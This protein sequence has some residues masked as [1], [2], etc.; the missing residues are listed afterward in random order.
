MPGFSPSAV[1]RGRDRPLQGRVARL[2]IDDAVACGGRRVLFDDEVAVMERGG[3]REPE[4]LLNLDE[5][6]LFV[7]APAGRGSDG[8][9]GTF[10]LVRLADGASLA[11]MGEL[12][13]DGERRWVAAYEFHVGDP[14]VY[15]YDGSCG[16]LPA[17]VVARK[18]QHPLAAVGELLTEPE[19]LTAAAGVGVGIVVSVWIAPAV[20]TAMGIEGT[21]AVLATEVALDVLIAGGTEAAIVYGMTGDRDRAIRGLAYAGVGAAGGAVI[22]RALMRLAQCR[23]LLATAGHGGVDAGD[24]RAGEE[25]LRGAAVAVRR[26]G[27]DEIVEVGKRYDKVVAALNGDEVLAETLMRD[28]IT[29]E[30]TDLLGIVLRGGDEELAGVV[31]AWKILIGNSTIRRQVASLESI[32]NYLNRYPDRGPLLKSL[33]EDAVENEDKFIS[34][35][36][37]LD[38]DLE[39]VLLSSNSL[40]LDLATVNARNWLSSKPGWHDVIIHGTP[41]EFKVLTGA[42][43]WV[44][45]NHRILV[46]YMSSKGYTGGKVRLVSC[47]TGV[48][49]DAVGQHLSNKLGVEVIAPKGYISVLPDGTHIVHSDPNDIFGT[50]ITDGWRSFIP[51]TIP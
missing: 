25:L 16:W 7:D 18:Y 8:S 41:D 39:S 1:R 24:L 5:G 22:G 14:A 38:D 12:V 2:R 49:H 27:G 6:D 37:R 17:E 36:N 15:M 32:S 29:E 3:P 31:R 46:N 40:G 11:L 51:G 35:V 44:S 13:I 42:D 9:S 47:Q 43:E 34:T 10:E 48:F 20:V 26:S 30:G 28:A 45:L 50:Q 21:A 33:F 19:V 23:R 4:R